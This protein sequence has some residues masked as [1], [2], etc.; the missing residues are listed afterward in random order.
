ME[1]NRLENEKTAAQREKRLKEEAEKTRSK[2]LESLL[3][4]AQLE[5]SMKE[6]ILAQ[7]QAEE[8]Y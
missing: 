2:V 5:Q 8:V 7:A 1:E 4:K 3:K 6:K